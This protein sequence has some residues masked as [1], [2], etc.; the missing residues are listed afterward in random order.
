[1]RKFNNVRF[2][3]P[4]I[5]EFDLGSGGD[6]NLRQDFRVF[7]TDGKEHHYTAKAGLITDMASIPGWAQ[8]IIHKEADSAQ[9]SMVHDDIYDKRPDDWTRKGADRLLYAGLRA[10]GMGWFKAKAMYLAVR[11]GG[12]RTWAT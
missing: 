6:W 4:L 11:A 8:S 7:W 9:A 2:P 12:K 1:M 5:L 3:D 10:T